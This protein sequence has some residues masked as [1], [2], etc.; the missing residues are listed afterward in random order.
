MENEEL[1]PCP[2]CGSKAI[3]GQADDG[4]YEGGHFVECTNDL[5]GLTIALIYA[6]GDDPKPL[7]SER[8]NRRVSEPQRVHP[9]TGP[10]N[11]PK[12]PN[13]YPKA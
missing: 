12:V 13:D 4:E 5:C 7:L 1:L 8:W 9:T 11:P 6:C 2:C 10:K 3:F